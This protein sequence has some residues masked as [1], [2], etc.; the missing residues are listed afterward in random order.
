[1]L[2]P[3]QGLLYM[4]GG[5]ACA[6]VARRH[7]CPKD[8]RNRAGGGLPFGATVAV[9]AIHKQWFSPLCE[10][11]NSGASIYLC[12]QPMDA[13]HFAEPIPAEEYSIDGIIWQ[14]D[15]FQ[16]SRCLARGTPWRLGN[17]ERRSSICHSREPGGLGQQHG[18]KWRPLYRWQ[19]RQSVSRN[20]GR[21]CYALGG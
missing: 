17:Y 11:S 14:P 1:M 18:I 6:G 20:H 4:K 16:Q 3:G 7:N 13:S 10:V 15:P 9:P 12:M 19:G 21:D 5:H 2:K 8:E